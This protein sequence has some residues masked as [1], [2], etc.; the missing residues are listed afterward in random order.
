[1]RI[2]LIHQYFL[3]KNEG[4]GSRF[5]EMSKFWAN[6]GHEITIVSGMVHYT[7]GIKNIKYKN[8]I[9]VQEEYDKNIT[10]YRCHVSQAYNK[11][12]IGRLWAYLSF[13]FTSLICSLFFVKNKH[14]LI[15]A[16]SPPLF[17][18]ITGIVVSFIKRI[19]LVFEIRDLWPESA[20]DTG[21]ISNPL[22]IKASYWLESIIYKRAKLINVLTPAFKQ[23]LMADK[24]VNS[25]KIIVISNAA[26]FSLSD[27]LL[28]NFN[29][30][31][32]RERHGFNNKFIVI[33]VG[34]HGVAN[35]LIQ[36]I[37]T[38]ELLKNTDVLMLLIGNG[39]QKTMLLNEVNIR[40]LKNVIFIDPVPKAEVFKFILAANIGASVL[41]KTETFKTVYSNKTF[42]YISCKKPVLMAIDGASR[43]LVE[44]AKCGL[45]V[46]PENAK[47]FA[48][49]ILFYR[50]NP[51][52]I[53]E[54]GQNGYLYAKEHFDREKLAKLYISKL[55]ENV[56]PHL[57]HNKK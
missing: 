11:N 12:F 52:K 55:E 50:N 23:K 10:V 40:D 30:V 28:K 27:Q 29:P 41:K 26:D 5:N 47:D 8:R 35:H 34:A 56:K 57:K 42:D 33:Y 32:F 45:Y 9:I 17:V 37:E 6:A 53:S 22:I 25:K 48:D 43:E 49:K 51:Q 54:H 44:N 1:M 15:L 2:L 24:K 18:G 7:T 20:I 19:P 38:A 16:S 31:K 14:D 39:M 21:V 3:E 13:I 46:E 4:G 36:M